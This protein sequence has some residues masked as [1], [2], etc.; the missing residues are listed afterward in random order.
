M[1]DLLGSD[2]ESDEEEGSDVDY[3]GEQSNQESEAEPEEGDDETW[4]DPA[5]GP[6][7][8]DVSLELLNDLNACS[9]SEDNQNEMELQSIEKS[10]TR[11]K[12]SGQSQPPPSCQN[13][14]QSEC[15]VVGPDLE[16]G[17]TE[18]NLLTY[19]EPE[20]E[21]AD[22]DII[23]NTKEQGEDTMEDKIQP[24]VEPQAQSEYQSG[25]QS[26]VEA[27]DED[28]RDEQALVLLFADTLLKYLAKR[29]VKGKTN[30]KFDGTLDE[31][32]DFVSLVLKSKGK[33][34]G[35]KNI[36]K[37]TFS[38][39]KAKLALSWWPT[40][41]TLQLQGTNE[42]VENF[43]S[44]LD[45]LLESI[46]KINPTKNDDSANLNEKSS[47]ISAPE[48]RKRTK[49]PETHIQCDSRE[50][51]EVNSKQ[52]SDKCGMPSRN[53]TSSCLNYLN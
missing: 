46:K 19:Q 48:K 13:Q 51:G 29:K 34:T 39:S 28:N 8:I 12:C 52:K 31:L 42:N 15:G 49:K 21:G 53:L 17:Q 45:N 1:E 37:Q 4:P 24:N 44:K 26:Q 47:R 9:V 7:Q 22:A 36:G 11:Y 43:E 41:K 18:V 6:N 14:M 38:D 50:E 30:Y 20:V 16:V 35:K 2:L 5:F 25:S 27:D 10:D 23:K 40:S 3:A 32:K 33:W